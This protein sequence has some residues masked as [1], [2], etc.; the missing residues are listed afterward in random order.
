M[1]MRVLG[2]VLLAALVVPAS[3]NDTTA[4][5]SSGGLVFL[6][7]ESISMDSEDLTVSPDGVKVVYTF[8]NSSDADQH[9]L[10]AF[11]LPDIKGDGDLNVAIPSV[12]DDNIFGF[13]TSFEGKPVEATHHEYAFATNIEYTDLLK[14]LAIPLEPFGEKTTAAIAALS[15]VQR[16]DL[17]A[18]GLV[19]PMEYSDDGATWKTD[20]TPIW[21]LRSTYSWEA[22][23]PAGKTVTVEHNYLPSVGGTVAVTFLAPPNED[24]DRA[25]DYRK[26]YCTDERLIASLKKKLKAPDDY[27]S[28]PYVE[29]W[30][31]YIWSTGANWS[32]PIKKFHLTI[33]KGD[34]TNLVSFC[35][36]GDVKKTGP[37]TFEMEAA[38]WY[39]PWN[40]E[41][42]ILILKDVSSEPV[43]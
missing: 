36:D 39:P 33:D 28:A 35:W 27:Y 31:S 8:T 16:A 30:I 6:N 9:V 38:D 5:L 1:S 41:L 25:A 19:I 43:G 7:N 12:D 18:K 34:A 14:D 10:V 40:R 24:E 2:L 13:T 17:I 32:G 15:D 37:A 26:K 4:V 3:A 42:D 22:I 23:F 21:T 20:Y 11:P 29:N